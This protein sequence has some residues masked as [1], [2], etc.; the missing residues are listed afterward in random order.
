MD[1]RT[2]RVRAKLTQDEVAALTRGELSQ[3]Q[4]SRLERGE[5][6]N[7]TLDTLRALARVYK[8]DL[9]DVVKA[10]AQTGRVA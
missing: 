2:M 9:A 4:L 8:C 7:P 1:L 6:L 5:S 10:V 3:V